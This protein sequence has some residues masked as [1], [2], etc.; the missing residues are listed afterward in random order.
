MWKGNN[1]L[2]MYKEGRTLKDKSRAISRGEVH[3]RLLLIAGDSGSGKSMGANNL[4]YELWK[5]DYTIIYVTEK[6]EQELDNAFCIFNVEKEYH[7]S[8]LNSTGMVKET[9]PIKI[10]H[11]LTENIPKTKLP[12]E[13]T[14]FSFSPQDISPMGFSTILNADPDKEVVRVCYTIAQHLKRDATMYEFMYQLKKGVT[15]KNVNVTSGKTDLM[16][17]MDSA[18]AGDKRTVERVLISFDVFN[19]EDFMIHEADTETKMDY[20]SM[21]NDNKNWHFLTTKW[22]KNKQTKIFSIITFMEGIV[23]NLKYAKHPVVL[24]F[25]EIKYLLPSSISTAFSYEKMLAKYLREVLTGVRAF[26]KG[27]YVIAT[28][29]TLKKC[30]Q[31]FIDSCNSRWYFKLTPDDIGK[32]KNEFN[33]SRD[34]IDLFLELRTGE[35]IVFDDF[36]NPRKGDNKYFCFPTPFMHAEEDYKFS[37]MYKK[38]YRDNLKDYNELVKGLSNKKKG[39]QTMYK[40]KFISEK[41]KEKSDGGEGSNISSSEGFERRN[42]LSKKLKQTEKQQVKHDSMKQAYMEKKD[43]PGISFNLLAKMN[44]VS[45]PTIQKWCYKIALENGDDEFIEKWN[46]ARFGS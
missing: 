6:V 30:N 41:N 21:I 11:P 8:I 36:M 27:V 23:K 16:T 25:E 31:E 22:I 28:T 45:T 1:Y 29:Q 10:Y 14:F 33:I 2:M 13:F 17:I 20:K 40:N 26:G 24:V 5:H 39:L 34:R 35:F 3:N 18:L 38:H 32:I 46:L 15:S 37:E 43:N 7:E 44:K 42:V 12:R 4:S 19:N 9:I